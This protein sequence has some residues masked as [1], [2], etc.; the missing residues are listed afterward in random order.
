MLDRTT[1]P[2][3]KEIGSFDIKQAENAQLENGR[4]VFLL[5][6]GT[7]PIFKLELVI[8]AGNWF[9]NRPEWVPLTLKMLNEGTLKRSGIEMANEID[10]LGAFIEFTPGFDFSSINIYSLSKHFESIVLLL[11]E[12]IKEPR[13]DEGDFTPLKKKEVQRL[14]LNQ[15]KTSYLAS[16]ALR[17]SIF[18]SEHP[19][20]RSLEI[21]RLEELNLPDIKSYYHSNF[22]DFDILVSGLISEGWVEILN[23]HFGQKPIAKAK[24]EL[25]IWPNSSSGIT[26]EKKDSVQSSIQIGKRLFN[27]SHSDYIPFLVMNKLLGGFFGSRLMKN[28]RE[29]KGLTYGIYSHLYALNNEGYFS[30]A[31]DV[32][33]ELTQKAIDEILKEVRLLQTE[34]APEDELETVKNYMLGTFSTSVSTPF[35]LMDR[36]K[37]VYYQNLDYGYYQDYFNTVKSIEAVDLLEQCEKHLAIDSLITC[38]VGPKQ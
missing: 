34:L 1:Q 16:I 23:R 20:G 7:Q 31:T 35:A 8:K 13:F 32:K 21:N 15:E 24:D 6:H 33:G 26:T 3:F 38:V 22:D 4:N 11:S 10:S 19:Y 17:K 5:N 28:I 29:D 9:A 30:I 12:V 18:G 27:R 25:D 36:F 2:L 14:K 37:A